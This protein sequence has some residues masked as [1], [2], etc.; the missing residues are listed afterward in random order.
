[1]MNNLAVSPYDKE[2][3]E[4]IYAET[5]D[6]SKNRFGLTEDQA[7]QRASQ[8]VISLIQ[9]F[10]ITGYKP[11]ARKM[12]VPITIDD[13]HFIL[14][15]RDELRGFEKIIFPVVLTCNSEALTL[16]IDFQTAYNHVFGTIAN[17]TGCEW[18]KQQ[19]E[20]FEVGRI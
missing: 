18:C 17:I 14:D 12:I 7:I 3:L 9:T 15:H 4:I 13:E 16:P 1:M 5:Y 6:Q 19:F 2:K 20:R 8:E 11:E 10:W